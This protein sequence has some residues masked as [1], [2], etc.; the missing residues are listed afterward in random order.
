MSPER[1]RGT[2]DI[3]GRSD[4]Y[5][6]GATL[7]AL[8]TGHPPFAGQTLVETITRIRQ[9]EPVKPGK[10]QMGI[11]SAFEGAVLKMLA[12]RPEDRFQRAAEVLAE[13][14]RISKFCALV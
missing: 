11:N 2:Q 1:T 14:E 12:K 6:L 3:D 10:Y 8:L 7:Y 5:S 4:I 9:S 13:L